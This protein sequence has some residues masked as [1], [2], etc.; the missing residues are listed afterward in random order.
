MSTLMET[1][2]TPEV[3]P[4]DHGKEQAKAQIQ[5]ILN[6][7]AEFTDEDGNFDDSEFN[8]W[9]NEDALSLEVRG[10]WHTPGAEAE[11]DEF[12]IV[13]CT[14]GPHVE[15]QGELDRYKQ[16]CRIRVMYNDWFRSLTEYRTDSEEDEAIEKYVACF[17]FGD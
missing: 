7:I 16:P 6:A 12:R 1:S 11:D 17:Y 8:D 9:V 15:I 14:G 10:A 4:V 13:M 2:N 3:T 5:S